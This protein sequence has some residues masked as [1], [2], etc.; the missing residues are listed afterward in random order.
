VKNGMAFA[1]MAV[2]YSSFPRKALLIKL[3][4]YEP[5]NKF[6]RYL[7]MNSIY[8][9]I[10]KLLFIAM[11]VFFSVQPV[12][13]DYH[14]LIDTN[15]SSEPAFMERNPEDMLSDYQGRFQGL[16]SNVPIP[17]PLPTTNLR[18]NLLHDSSSTL[19]PLEQASVFRC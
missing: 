17:M 8:R 15:L 4:S 1:F 3:Q 18:K 6:F 2:K 19:T 11:L 14:I 9:K 7:R 5:Q 12:L 13:E 10:E 16:E